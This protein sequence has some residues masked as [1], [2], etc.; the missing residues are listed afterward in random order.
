[1][2]KRFFGFNFL[3]KKNTPNFTEGE[4][5]R[6]F[7]KA[8]EPL[9]KIPT[10]NKYNNF[11]LR[12]LY[13]L[14][15]ELFKKFFII[16]NNETGKPIFNVVEFSDT[17]N[18]E[19]CGYFTQSFSLWL[20]EQ[21]YKNGKS[22]VA[23][24]DFPFEEIID[25]I[26]SIYGENN[27][28]IEI[29]NIIRKKFDGKIIH[30]NE[31]ALYYIYGIYDGLIFNKKNNSK[32]L[33]SFDK[34]PIYIAQFAN[35]F[36]EYIIAHQNESFEILKKED[37][38][39]LEVKNPNIALEIYDTLMETIN[40]HKKI[41]S[42][43][44]KEERLLIYFLCILP[45]IL[46]EE[47][48]LP[49]NE[50]NVYFDNIKY[51]AQNEGVGI[52]YYTGAF[53]LWYLEQM[54]IQN[55]ELEN[56]FGFNFFELELAFKNKFDLNGPEMDYYQ[57]IK[58]SKDLDLNDKTTWV[59]MYFYNIFSVSFGD[60][61]KLVMALYKYFRHESDLEQTLTKIE[62]VFS[63]ILAYSVNRFEIY[64]NNQ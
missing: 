39:S 2:E 25:F 44:V 35:S 31:W 23:D 30:P 22:F 50:G 5:F 59:K 51:A 45:Q 21:K 10:D 46:F 63:H 24:V 11:V 48:F 55:P 17:N 61:N 64:N 20:L 40:S 32:A 58:Q 29:L 56:K 34:S 26:N 57:F 27:R 3:A 12:H 14:P 15:I 53:G 7:L 37:N 38:S 33:D 6:D 36:F 52:A 13:V 18:G 41:L 60:E 47:L 28:I 16:P 1:M 9:G 8:F 4:I 42:I 19:F 62:S 54:M 43:Q 49:D